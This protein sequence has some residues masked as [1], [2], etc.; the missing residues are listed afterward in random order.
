MSIAQSAE[1]REEW[2]SQQML[3]LTGRPLKGR[4][5]IFDDTSAFMSIER[6]HIIDLQGEFFLVR[7]ND[8]ILLERDT[9]E[10][11]W[12]DFDLT[13]DFP[14]H[15]LAGVGNILHVVFGKR[16]IRF[17]D[18]LREHPEL[19]SHLLSDDGAAFFP[20]RV[21]NL[22]AVFPYVPRK[23]NDILMRFSIGADVPYENVRQVVEDL[24]DCAASLGWPVTPPSAAT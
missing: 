17:R 22:H 4:S 10:F 3:R 2:I 23:F 12:I 5:V 18:M 11:R 15:D 19:S 24:E 13:Q 1:R 21:M 7:C 20:L 8:H 6:D 9:G 16:L 14:D